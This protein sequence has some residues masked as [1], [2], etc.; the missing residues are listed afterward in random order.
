MVP[1]ELTGE[2]FKRSEVRK[3]Y[4]NEIKLNTPTML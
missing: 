1:A 4:I 3:L 2:Y